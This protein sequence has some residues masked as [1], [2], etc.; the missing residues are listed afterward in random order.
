LLEYFVGLEILPVLNA[1]E[2]TL[3]CGR[4]FGFCNTRQF[5]I[6]EKIQN[7]RTTGSEYFKNFKEPL[8]GL[9]TISNTC[10]LWKSP[11]LRT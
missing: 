11:Y 7:Q 1:R 8:G 9:C 3:Q 4:V 6:F 5:G 10:P 2:L